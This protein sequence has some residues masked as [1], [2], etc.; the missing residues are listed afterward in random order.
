[1]A[2]PQTDKRVETL[3]LFFDLVFV[4]AITQVTALMSDDPSWGGL[5]RGLLV[6]AAIWWAWAAYAWLTNEVGSRR[7]AVRLAMFAAMAAML[8]ASLAIPGAFDGDALLFAC[9]YLAVR[10]LHIVVFAAAATTSTYARP[11]GRSLRPRFSPPLCSWSPAHS[12][13]LPRSGCGSWRCSSTTSAPRCGASRA[14]G[15]RPATSRS[16]TG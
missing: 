12:T 7:Q 2:A 5:L 14:G 8:L 9:A 4:F 13:G 15:C 16:A 11:R 1:M 3:E 6:L 10:V